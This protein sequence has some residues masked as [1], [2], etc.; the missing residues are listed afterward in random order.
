MQNIYLVGFMA[1]GKTCVGREIA[2]REKWQ[3]A[4]LDELIELKEKRTITDIFAQ[5][6][7]AYFRRIEKNTL[8]EIAREKRFVVSCGGG[9]V[10]DPENIRIMQATGE[11]ICLSASPAVILERSRL[12][13]SRP[14]LKVVDP[15]KQIEL[16][17]K[18]R[19]PFYR[20]IEK[21]IDTSTLTIEQVTQ[22]VIDLVFGKKPTAKKPSYRKIKR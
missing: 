2:R 5:Q 4:D 12:C 15:K 9:I 17:L 19:Q 10:I 21:N 3:F 18:L 14:L 20:R 1:T 8:K 11:V 16:L 13:A 7:E 6:G 22:R